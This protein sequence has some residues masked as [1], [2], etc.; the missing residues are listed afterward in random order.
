MY[1]SLGF[2][3]P[4]G[5]T[6]YTDVRRYND[7]QHVDNAINYLERTKGYVLDEMFLHPISGRIRLDGRLFDVEVLDSTHVRLWSPETSTELGYGWHIGQLGLE[8]QDDLRQIV[9]GARS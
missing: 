5:R 7:R 1:A 8:V 4:S 6:W 9:K 2:K 3:L